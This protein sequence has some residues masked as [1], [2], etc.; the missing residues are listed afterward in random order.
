MNE[1]IDYIMNECEVEDDKG[2]EALSPMSVYALTDMIANEIGASKA[3][4]VLTTIIKKLKENP[5]MWRHVYAADTVL[6]TIKK[7]EEKEMSE[8]FDDDDE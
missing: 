4:F 3:I 2:T 7:Q 5:D 8:L 1:V 6:N